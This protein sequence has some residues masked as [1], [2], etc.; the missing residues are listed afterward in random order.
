MRLCKPMT[1]ALTLLAVLCGCQDKPAPK[2]YTDTFKMDSPKGWQSH[3]QPF[4]V[5]LMMIAPQETPEDTFTETIT[6]AVEGSQDTLSAHVEKNLA[7]M[8]RH[9]LDFQ[10]GPP[11]DTTIDGV[12]AR[13]LIATCTINGVKAKMIAFFVVKNG[14]GFAIAATCSAEEFPKHEP[15]FRQAVNTFRFKPAAQS[16]PS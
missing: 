4:G 3:T 9:L 14:L 8:K 13:W 10:A 16:K 1:V 6:V 11:G 7:G 15:Q 5:V 12:R 2:N